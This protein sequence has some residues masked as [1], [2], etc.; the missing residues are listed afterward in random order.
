MTPEEFDI[1]LRKVGP[2]LARQDT[3]LRKAI[4]AK[5]RLPL[6]LRF[7]ATGESFRFLSCKYRMGC[8]T[9]SKVIFETCTVIRQLLKEEFLQLPKPEAAWRTVAEG[10][11][12]KWQFPHCVG[13]LDTKRISIQDSGHS[14]GSFRSSKEC[15]VLLRAAVDADYKFLYIS[16]GAQGED[17]DASLFEDSDFRRALDEGLLHLPPA[18][19]LPNSDIKFP[20]VFI[21]DAVYPLRSDLLTPFSSEDMDRS[22][23][24]F[25]HQLSRARRAVEHAF[26][27]LANG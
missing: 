4:P 11:L 13:A 6:T 7:L 2:R 23:R 15:P 16:V 12:Q 9:V 5:D 18:E 22:Q 26:S 20:Y 24:S 8:S 10:F 14:G 19:P 21:G 17:S 25:N 3:K 1:L 27:I